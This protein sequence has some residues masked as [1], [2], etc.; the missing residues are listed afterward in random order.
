[1]FWRF[2]FSKDLAQLKSSIDDELL[3]WTDCLVRRVI[4]HRTFVSL[5]WAHAGGRENISLLSLRVAECLVVAIYFLAPWYYAQT[6]KNLSPTQ[7]IGWPHIHQAIVSVA[8]HKPDHLGGRMHVGDIRL[9]FIL[10]IQRL[11]LLVR[12]QSSIYQTHC[13]RLRPTLVL[14]SLRDDRWQRWR[15]SEKGRKNVG[16]WRGRKTIIV[17]FEVA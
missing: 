7:S 11:N 6:T 15:R 1:M 17:F 5:I 8:F 14:L 9:P 13:P 4:W 12:Q 16:E 10:L 2:V 3:L